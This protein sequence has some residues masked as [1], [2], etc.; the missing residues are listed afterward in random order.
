MKGKL[1]YQRIFLLIL[2]AYLLALMCLTGA[3]VYTVYSRYKNLVQIAQA[4]LTY[5]LEAGTFDTRLV[6]YESNNFVYGPEGQRVD[7]L[8]SD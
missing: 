6:Q 4:D 8:T 5:Y 7:F 3:S 1:T 2:C